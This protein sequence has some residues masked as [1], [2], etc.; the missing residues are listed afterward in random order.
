M[1]TLDSCVPCVGFSI[2]NFITVVPR[3]ADD[4]DDDCSKYFDKNKVEQGA[5]VG[6]TL[7]SSEISSSQVSESFALS[8]V[9]VWVILTFNFTFTTAA[10]IVTDSFTIAL[11]FEIS[12]ETIRSALKRRRI[13]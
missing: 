4:D 9:A 3:R 12:E 13:W 5:A 7:G 1:E 11:V 8:L 2:L 10:F 6:V